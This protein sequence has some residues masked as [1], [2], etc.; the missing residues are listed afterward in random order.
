ME[1]DL[2]SLGVLNGAAEV[3]QEGNYRIEGRLLSRWFEAS[4]RQQLYKPGFMEQ[5]YIG[6]HHVWN[7]KFANIESSQ[8]NGYLHYRSKAVH[9]SPGLT[10]TRLRN[11]VYFDRLASVDTVQQVFP[12]QSQGN[13]IYF[14]PE[15]RFSIR[16][17]R[18]VTLTNQT[19]YTFFA[20]N[21]DDAI[22]VPE[23]FVNAQLA[24][25]NIHFDGNLD[26]QAG[27]ELHWH[28]AY[29]APAYDPAIRQFY[30]QDDFEVNAFPVIDLFFNAKIKR[31]RILLKWN[32]LVQL[33]TGTGY[34]PTPYYPGQRNIIDFGFDWSFY[35]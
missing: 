32:N 5:A 8:I 23:L 6:A 4:V 2:D 7:N 14:S 13:H 30:N 33:V 35:D 34:F 31:G 27:V 17:L 24:Y 9:I 29:Y 16:F 22:R 10:F 12:V 18:H 20:E 3:N 15:L 25:S 11:Y 1:L 21:A 28:S 19:V 26:M